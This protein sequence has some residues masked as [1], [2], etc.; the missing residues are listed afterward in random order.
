M[1]LAVKC[2]AAKLIAFAHEALVHQSGFM[3]IVDTSMSEISWYID[4]LGI[5]RYV[6]I[7]FG[8]LQ[9]ILLSGVPPVARLQLHLRQACS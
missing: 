4:V 1:Y 3:E 9:Q 6:V 5:S 2:C 7:S 8:N